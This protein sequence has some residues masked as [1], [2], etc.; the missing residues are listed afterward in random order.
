MLRLSVSIQVVDVGDCP[1]RPENL[2]Q[3]PFGV[4]LND[5][6][7]VADIRAV[8][9]RTEDPMQP[10]NGERGD[11]HHDH[12]DQGYPSALD[13]ASHWNL[14]G[15]LIFRRSPITLDWPPARSLRAMIT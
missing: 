9:V 10:R 12:H 15:R 14:L 1:R 6:I 2:I 4:E 11:R 5:R 8:H 13:E 3:H 7:G